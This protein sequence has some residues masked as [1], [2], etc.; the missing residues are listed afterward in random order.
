MGTGVPSRALVST[1][2]PGSGPSGLHRRAESS[3]TCQGLRPPASPAGPHRDSVPS[4]RATVIPRSC[5]ST[6]SATRDRSRPGSLINNQTSFRGADGGQ[7]AISLPAVPESPPPHH[8]ASRDADSPSPH[9]SQKDLKPPG[10]ET[11]S[12]PVQVSGPRTALHPFLCFL[13]SMNG[14][15]LFFLSF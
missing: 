11:V 13:F 9:C 4:P 3:A 7:P 5:R 8:S 6:L 12:T 15:T 10:A 1:E 14:N 2:C